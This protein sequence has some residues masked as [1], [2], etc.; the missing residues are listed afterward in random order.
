MF[1]IDPRTD[2]II[3]ARELHITNITCRLNQKVFGRKCGKKGCT[4]CTVGN[5]RFHDLP[6]AW[7]NVFKDQ[8]FIDGIV[9][10]EPTG[11]IDSYNLFLQKIDSNFT[12]AEYEQFVQL[13]RSKE[14]V[15]TQQE[16]RLIDFFDLF[17]SWII[18][19]F[20]YETWFQNAQNQ[21]RY[22]AYQLAFNLERNTCCYCNRMYTATV[23]SN[24]G[25]K[26]MRPIFDHWYPQY[27]Y[28]LLALSFYNLIPSCTICNSNIKGKKLPQEKQLHPYSSA[29]VID[30][31]R[32]SFDFEGDT[33]HFKIKTIVGADNAPLTE[34]IADQKLELLYQAHPTELADMLMMAKSYTPDYIQ[35]I[36][37]LFPNDCLSHKEAYRLAFGTEIDPAD[38][39]RR[40]LSKFRSDILA[41]LQLISYPDR[42]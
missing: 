27:K 35:Q 4:V 31:F 42:D 32:F 41:E 20:D 25:K 18:K 40:P 37:N 17:N 23:K 33:S 12:W 21:K 28:P 5:N 1:S 38:F 2:V 36:I 30:G 10:G 13:D 34:A 6:K 29:N 3:N 15:P 11:L 14:Y 7:I 16:Q 9:G 39:H 8:A 19:L 26:V 24:Y 22:D